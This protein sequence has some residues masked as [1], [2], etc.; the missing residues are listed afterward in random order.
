[1]SEVVVEPLEMV[2]IELIMPSDRLTGAGG[3]RQIE[4][5]CLFQIAAVEPP[6]TNLGID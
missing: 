5:E 2:D 4:F 3:S 1:M 6:V